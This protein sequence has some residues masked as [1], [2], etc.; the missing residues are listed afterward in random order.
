VV[1]L[2][3]PVRDKIHWL[4]CT[5]PKIISL[6]VNNHQAGYTMLKK[7]TTLNTS[8]KHSV[9]NYVQFPASS[10]QMTVASFRAT[11]SED[12]R[13]PRPETPLAFRKSR[14]FADHK[15]FLRNK[16]MVR[17]RKSRRGEKV[18]YFV[19]AASVVYY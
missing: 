14:S 17:R 5:C 1:V 2:E 13:S 7:V 15:R 10:L 3:S 6:G 12:F 4:R 8:G 16:L 19:R 18:N 11:L 9:K